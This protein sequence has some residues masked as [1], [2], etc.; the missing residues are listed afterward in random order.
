MPQKNSRKRLQLF[1][2]SVIFWNFFWGNL[3]TK[4]GTDFWVSDS[5]NIEEF[6]PIYE[7]KIKKL[8]M[9]KKKFQ[10]FSGI[11]LRH[12]EFFYFIFVSGIT[13]LYILTSTG[14]EIVT[15]LHFPKAF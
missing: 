13:F 11:F 15:G 6:N 8:Q 2:I 7:K 3:E 10:S 9:Q 5:C 12:L 4:L 14:G 1:K